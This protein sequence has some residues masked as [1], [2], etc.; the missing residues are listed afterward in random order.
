M[1]ATFHS[2]VTPFSYQPHHISTNFEL[3]LIR[4]KYADLRVQLKLCCYICVNSVMIQT[5]EQKFQ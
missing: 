4:V 3:S 1:I 5:I 2:S